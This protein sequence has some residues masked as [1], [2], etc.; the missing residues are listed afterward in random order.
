MIENGE[1]EPD[2]P[3]P[4]TRH[5]TRSGG[6]RTSPKPGAATSVVV[7][8]VL[9]SRGRRLAGQQDSES[10]VPPPRF[11]ASQPLPLSITCAKFKLSYFLC[12]TIIITDVNFS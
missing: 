12:L 6:S 8:P 1:L 3:A 11:I 10:Q 7:G 9:R 5:L 4:K 2:F